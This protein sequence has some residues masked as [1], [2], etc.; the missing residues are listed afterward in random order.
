MQSNCI[1]A[2]I[3]LAAICC[4]KSLSAQKFLGDWSG[5]VDIGT[6]EL[7]INIQIQRKDNDTLALLGIPAQGL[8]AGQASNIHS[9]GDSLF[10]EWEAFKINY[11]GALQADNT[12]KGKLIQGLHQS[13]LDLAKGIESLHRPQEPKAPFPYLIEE[14][15]FSSADGTILQ[16]TL[17]KPKKLKTYPLVIIVSGSGPQDRDGAMFGHKPYAVLADHLTRNGIAVFRYDERGV[18]KSQGIFETTSIETF[19]ADI[20]AAIDY[21]SK[22]KDVFSKNLGL[23]GHSIGGIIAPKEAIGNIKVK[24]LVLMA[25]PGVAGDQLM[26][27]QKASVEKHLG[28][29]EFQ[30]NQGQTI[31]GNAY[32]IIRDENLPQQLLPDSL[33]AFFSKQ[34]GPLFPK[35]QREGLVQQLTSPELMAIVTASPSTYLSKLEIPVLALN[36]TKDFQVAA[37]ENL[38]AIEKAVKS[39]GNNKVLIQKLEGRNHLFQIAETG[40]QDEYAEL[41]QTMDPETMNIISSW[42]NQLK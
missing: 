3:L 4:S 31:F 18:G 11:H 1:K 27:A 20:N 29:N 42:I 26:L 32:K 15:S 14:L 8:T 2:L 38:E 40:M 17:T 9:K 34:L 28:L 36:G 33:N 6:K 24:Y 35:D 21:L 7:A 13:T 23:I 41:E 37:A 22:R 39:N 25:A 16:G 30:I 12:I 10:I 5:K 19:Q